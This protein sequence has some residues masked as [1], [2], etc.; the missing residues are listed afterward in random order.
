MKE[1]EQNPEASRGLRTREF[2]QEGGDDREGAV[3][4][5][6]TVSA[7]SQHTQR[8]FTSH[9]FP[10]QPLTG[11]GTGGRVGAEG[12]FSRPPKSDWPCLEAEPGG[13]G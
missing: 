13:L 3:L 9:Q 7:L 10:V 5:L 8:T 11:H 6:G 2:G 4:P 12:S 1:L